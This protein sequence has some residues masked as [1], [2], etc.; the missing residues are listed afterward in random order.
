[1]KKTPPILLL[2]EALLMSGLCTHTVRVK[3]DSEYYL[4][5]I[6]IRNHISYDAVKKIQKLT[7]TY[8]PHRDPPG[9]PKWTH[10]FSRVLEVG[11]ELWHGPKLRDK[12]I[13]NKM[14]AVRLYSGAL[15]KL[16]PR[17]H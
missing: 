5:C 15:K 11:Y 13:L 12:F 16:S 7:D 4:V 8:F 6:N 17:K 2:E 10:H 14:T 9:V 3:L 1:M